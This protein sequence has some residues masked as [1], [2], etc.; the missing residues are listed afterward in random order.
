[1]ILT[2]LIYPYQKSRKPLCPNGLRDS[3]ICRVERKVEPNVYPGPFCARKP[4]G[5]KDFLGRH[6]V[7][8]S[9]VSFDRFRPVAP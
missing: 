1:M 5:R 6:W 9:S 8:I 7:D 2:P 4:L 3:S